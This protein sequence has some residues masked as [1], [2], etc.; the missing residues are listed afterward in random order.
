MS[1]TCK[2]LIIHCIDFRLMDDIYA[3]LRENGFA[4]DCDTVSLAGAS[5][6]LLDSDRPEYGD[7]ILKQIRISHDLHKMRRVIL[8]H[9]TDCGAYGGRKAFGDALEEE[10][11]H[12]HDMQEASRKIKSRWSDVETVL[13][14][15]KMG[16]GE[17]EFVQ[18][19]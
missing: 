12:I 5:K 7:F 4:G 15:I 18:I 6:D 11:R 2:N 8:M 16:G 1:H 9:H 3:W 17:N 14:L 10:R 13:V 19:R